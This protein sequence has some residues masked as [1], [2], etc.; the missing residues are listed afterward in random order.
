[1]VAGVAQYVSAYRE[2]DLTRSAPRVTIDDVMKPAVSRS[3]Q[4]GAL[5]GGAFLVVGLGGTFVARRRSR[6]A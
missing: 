6:R 1:M 2:A 4:Q 5:W 3:A